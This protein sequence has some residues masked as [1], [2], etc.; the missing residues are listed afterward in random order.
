MAFALSLPCVLLLI[1]TTRTA[2]A[3]THWVGSWAASQQIPEPGNALAPDD[4]HDATLR[5]VVHLS[6][7]GTELR[8]HISNRFGTAP[9]IFSAVHIAKP[10]SPA[11]AKI[12][13]G[14]DHPLTFSGTTEVTVPAGADYI[15]D[16]VAFSASPLSDLAITLYIETSPARQ[17]GHPG[18]R[19][20][21]Y[22][23]HGNLVSASDLPA[24]KTVEHWYF[25]FRRRCRRF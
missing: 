15:S 5:Q 23:A 11:S 12:V 7:G 14:T 8:V 19:A 2:R 17:T 20:T 25:P 18:A 6:I 9:L 16:P 3:Q 22:L 21:S 10:A 4:L 13:P 24:S 1:L